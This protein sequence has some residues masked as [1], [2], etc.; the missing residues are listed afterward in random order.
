MLDTWA[1]FA[2]DREAI[3][4][5][6]PPHCRGAMAELVQGYTQTWQLIANEPQH[7]AGRDRAHMADRQ[8]TNAIPVALHT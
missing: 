6:L 5:S 3:A 2:R 8:S 1:V 7:G 4:A